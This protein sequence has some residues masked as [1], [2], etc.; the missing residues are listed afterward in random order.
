MDGLHCGLSDPIALI[1]QE[2]SMKQR[3]GVVAG[4]VALTA[5]AVPAASAADDGPPYCKRVTAHDLHVW[6]GDDT[7]NAWVLYDLGKGDVWYAFSHNNGL[8]HGYYDGLS[9]QQD[10]GWIT[11]DSRWTEPIPCP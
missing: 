9:G 7:S 3:I 1:T 2:T 11:M 10:W 8:Y 4:I 5:L 6:S